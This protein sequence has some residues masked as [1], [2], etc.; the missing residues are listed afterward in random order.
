MLIKWNGDGLCYV[1]LTS[2]NQEDLAMV[3]KEKGVILVPG[4]N[5]VPPN[6]WKVI[7][8]HVED[9]ISN[10]RVELRCKVDETGE[11]TVRTEQAIYEVRADLARAI[12]QGCY[13][14]KVLEGWKD[15][16]KLSSELRNLVDIQLEKCT[17]GEEA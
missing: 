9:Y 6:E 14:F 17:K 11:K 3:A 12:I 7:E 10:G 13:N 1:P 4:W 16:S 2:N 5:D 15:N 8:A